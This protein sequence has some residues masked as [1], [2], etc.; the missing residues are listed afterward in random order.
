VILKKLAKLSQNLAKLIEFTLRKEKKFLNCFGKNDKK[1]AEKRHRGYEYNASASPVVGAR[2]VVGL[3][4]TWLRSEHAGRS[5]DRS[6]HIGLK[7]VL[8]KARSLARLLAPTFGPLHPCSVI[9]GLFSKISK[10][11]GTMA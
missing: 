3:I 2:K 10:M 9:L 5:V 11:G 6:W 7:N 4:I 8:K 1:F